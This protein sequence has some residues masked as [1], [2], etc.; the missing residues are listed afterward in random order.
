MSY[1]SRHYLWHTT[2]KLSTIRLCSEK[3]KEFCNPAQSIFWV[4]SVSMLKQ[5]L[6]PWAW[7]NS[8]SFS[9]NRLWIK[10]WIWSQQEERLLV[11]CLLNTNNSLT[12]IMER[13]Q[14]RSKK[15]W[16]KQRNSF[17]RLEYPAKQGIK[18]LH[19]INLSS[20]LYSKRP[21]KQ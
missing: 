10:D 17:Y 6:W 2:V 15:Y 21:E 3:H 13:S 1:I 7:S 19:P 11:R 4:S 12:I 9:R 14:A 18:K 20:A 16:T 8:S 5:W